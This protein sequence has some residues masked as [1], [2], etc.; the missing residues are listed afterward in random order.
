MDKKIIY[1]YSTKG[2]VGKSTISL[3]L[4]FYLKK[5]KHKVTLIDLD[6]SGPSIHRLIE[7]NYKNKL[8]MVDFYIMPLKIS[9][10]NISSIG[11]IKS[12]TE[13]SFLNGKYAEGAIDQFLHKKIL[14]TSDIIIIDMPPGFGEFHR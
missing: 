4:A 2:G 5:L 12:P 3:N 7:K 1:V 10:I 14:E 11:F 8:R 9:G 13:I 6:F